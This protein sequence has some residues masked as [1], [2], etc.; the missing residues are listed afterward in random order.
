MVCDIRAHGP[1]ILV[2]DLFSA[3][4]IFVTRGSAYAFTVDCRHGGRVKFCAANT[5]FISVIVVPIERVRDSME[6]PATVTFVA[7]PNSSSGM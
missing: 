4:G 3:S 2:D 5:A 1:R 6:V 7:Q